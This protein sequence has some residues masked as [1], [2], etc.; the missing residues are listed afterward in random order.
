MTNTVAHLEA[1]ACEV[2]MV[3]LIADELEKRNVSTDGISESRKKDLIDHC[4][5]LKIKNYK[6]I[7]YK[8]YFF[9]SNLILVI[10]K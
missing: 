4:E 1:D 9:T 5:K 2:A 7:P 3:S 8:L 10:Q 6:I